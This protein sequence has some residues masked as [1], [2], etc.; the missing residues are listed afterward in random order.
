M[1]APNIATTAP[2]PKPA[3]SA[4]VTSN[5]SGPSSSSSA[6]VPV[7]VTATAATMTSYAQQSFQSPV[8]GHARQTPQQPTPSPVS[9]Q[10][11][12]PNH[13]PRNQHS[14]LPVN[15]NVSIKHENQNQN[16]DA[17]N[18]N[19]N[20]STNAA[21]ASKECIDR[22]SAA[23]ALSALAGTK[24]TRTVRTVSNSPTCVVGDAG[25]TQ[26]QSSSSPVGAP[27]KPVTSLDQ[28]SNH[29][30]GHVHANIQG[31]VTF[32]PVPNP[33]QR[34]AMITPSESAKRLK[35]D[36][37]RSNSIPSQSRGQGQQHHG[38]IV[39]QGDAQ[40]GNV[41]VRAHP[42]VH[43]FPNQHSHPHPSMNMNH[44]HGRPAGYGYGHHAP[45]G[46]PINN[47]FHHGHHQLQHHPQPYVHGHGPP[48]QPQLY[49]HHHS[50]SRGPSPTFSMPPHGSSPAFPLAA[51]AQAQGQCPPGPTS[52]MHRPPTMNMSM[53]HQQG[54]NMN[55]NPHGM[56]HNHPFDHRG[57]NRSFSSSSPVPHAIPSSNMNMEMNSNMQTGGPHGSMHASATVSPSTK[58]LNSQTSTCG[59]Q[60][61]AQGPAGRMQMNMNSSNDKNIIQDQNQSTGLNLSNDHFNP[62]GS[63]K[64]K[65]KSLGVLCVNFM[66]RYDTLKKE[67]P[68]KSPAIS[69]DEAAHTL[70][71]ERRRI[72]DIINILEAINVVSRKCK[73]TYNWHG[74]ENIHDMFLKLQKGAFDLFPDDAIANGFKK[75]DSEPE[76]EV[77]S[78]DGDAKCADVKP[79]VNEIKETSVPLRS[80]PTGLDLLLAGAEQVALTTNARGYKKPKRTSDKEKSLGRLSQ[81]FIQL[82]L[83][84]NETIALSDASDKIL[85]ETPTLEPPPG[86][87]VS[88]ILLAKSKAN[89]M[90]KTKIRR[91]YDI[92]NVM[93][94][95]GLIAKINGGSNTKKGSGRPSF[96]WIYP[97]TPKDY[98]EKGKDAAKGAVVIP[99][100]VKSE[101]QIVADSNIAVDCASASAE[102]PSEASVST[103][104][105]STPPTLVP[106][107]ISS[108]DKIPG[109]IMV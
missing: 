50:H 94:S 14:F 64:R 40:H 2:E 109:S 39:F 27:K 59:T 43:P 74:M 102:T 32:T 42:H 90:L 62:D 34:S 83:V 92:A 68:D 22:E 100:A 28:G 69:I 44:G 95:I 7:N 89:K 67:S 8:V 98:L 106:N 48:R 11:Q 54:M 45:H 76:S 97:V 107:P 56:N 105:E 77:T 51:Q 21:C 9:G 88:D 80:M 93:V 60:E 1:S 49:H 35:L 5:A 70:Q 96:K 41:N 25:Q 12:V 99:L 66:L 3:P 26:S 19:A 103:S 36:G 6:P 57:N 23:L 73:N 47:G 108:D 81:K 52:Y 65:D 24:R 58:E 85:G 10:V 31:G 37:G 4:S 53:N 72:Y 29:S 30:H 17:G 15:V 33:N 75:A 13:N 61:Q 101:A 46:H 20:A 55:R 78:G 82:F 71:V 79:T 84:G 63:Y 104:S 38:A 16:Q 91:L 18:L 87:S 86:S